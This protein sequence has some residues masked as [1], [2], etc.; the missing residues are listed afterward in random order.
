[1]E[2]IEISSRII[3]EGQPVFI[4][5]EAGVNHNGD[6][7]LALDLVRQAKQCGADCVKFQ[8]F[9]AEEVVTEKAPKA[10]YQLR[11]TDPE[12]SQLEMLKKL[13]LSENSYHE[14]IALCKK[15]DIVFLSTPYAFGDADFLSRL[16]VEA[17][18]IASGQVVELFFLDYVAKLGKPIF[19]STG[20]CTL[21]EVQEGLDIIRKT[22]NG[23]VVIFQCTT[24]YPSRI[25]DANLKAMITMKNDLN[26]LV[27]YSDHTEGI[28]AVLASVALGAVVVEKHFT[29]NRDLPGPDH[30]SSLEPT[31]FTQMVQGIRKV[32]EALGSPVK[33]PTTS[34][35]KNIVGMRRSIVALK[36][37]PAG[38]TISREFLAFKRP[39]TGLEPKKL[40]KILGKKAKK[41]IPADTPFTHD[42]I[43]W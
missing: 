15:L 37:I 7:R 5:A 36:P 20:M 4:I 14:I 41:N 32:E 28:H 2:T 21:N 27:G 22:G 26:T 25:G 40:E 16:G 33:K 31:E 43:E 11:V 13:E 10:D 1:M 34:E 12:E 6:V 39:A 23:R 38:T 35:M 9:K 17:F 29:L 24:N 18:K 19:V 42:V 3:G 8:T 30:S